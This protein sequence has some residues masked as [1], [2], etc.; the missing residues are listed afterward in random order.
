MVGGPDSF[1]SLLPCTGK[2]RPANKSMIAFFHPEYTNSAGAAPK[3]WTTVEVSIGIVAACLP[4]MAPLFMRASSPRE[5]Y[6]SIRPV[7]ARLSPANQ[8]VYSMESLDD[9]DLRP[10]A[11]PSSKQKIRVCEG[12]Q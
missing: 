1:I 4:T 6:N 3:F 2:I 10:F 5:L 12:T 11:Q 8:E 7:F 9:L